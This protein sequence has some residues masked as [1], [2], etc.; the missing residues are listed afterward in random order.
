MSTRWLA[1]STHDGVVS[2]VSAL[3]MPATVLLPASITY[4]Y[5]RMVGNTRR[6]WRNTSATRLSTE[7]SM[8]TDTSLFGIVLIG[9]VIVVGALTF[10]PALAPGPLAEHVGMVS[11][12][13]MV[14][15]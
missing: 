3:A 7:G 15:R 12:L 11:A 8:P 6:S 13:P 9:T 5:G 14:A 4:I 2:A 10:L 1:Q